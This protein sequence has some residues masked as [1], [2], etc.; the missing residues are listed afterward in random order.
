MKRALLALK[1]VLSKLRRDC[2]QS[3]LQVPHIPL[4]TSTLLRNS[5]TCMRLVLCGAVVD[6]LFYDFCLVANDY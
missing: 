4:E 3:N 2:A 6:A 5:T 1:K